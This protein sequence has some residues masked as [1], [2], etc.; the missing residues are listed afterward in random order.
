MLYSHHGHL[1]IVVGHSDVKWV[2]SRN[3]RWSPSGY[4]T[5]IGGRGCFTNGIQSHL[6][7]VR[8]ESPTPP[9]YKT[10]V[11]ENCTLVVIMES[12]V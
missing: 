1:N 3:D 5:L 10:S 11:G 8:I 12:N 6:E 2:G 7:D 9:F 4:Y